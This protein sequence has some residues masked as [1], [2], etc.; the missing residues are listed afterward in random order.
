MLNVLILVFLFQAT[1]WHPWKKLD[2][3]EGYRQGL[4]QSRQGDVFLSAGRRVFMSADFGTSWRAIADTFRSDVT[5]I[6]IDRDHITVT[7]MFPTNTNSFVEYRGFG[8][9]NRPF[10]LEAFETQYVV[11]IYE[12]KPGLLSMF[13]DVEFGF[14]PQYQTSVD[15]GKTW[16][17]TPDAQKWA[18]RQDTWSIDG[19]EFYT[20]QQRRNPTFMPIQVDALYR[21]ADD[22]TTAVFPFSKQTVYSGWAVSGGWNFPKQVFK[23]RDTLFAVYGHYEGG[24]LFFSLDNGRNFERLNS[25]PDSLSQ[26]VEHAGGMLASRKS[27]LYQYK[28]SGWQV[29]HTFENP[30][31]SL[32]SAP[33]GHVFVEASGVFRGALTSVSNEVNISRKPAF[34]LA[35]FPNPFN[36]STVIRWQVPEAGR[37]VLTVWDV[38]GRMVRT[39]ENR[40]VAAGHQ[41]TRF[42]AAGLA[43]GVY[44]V[45]L[46]MQGNAL[47][48]RKITLLK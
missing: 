23:Q 42:D 17:H 13:Y 1:G 5:I 47:L 29:V 16:H 9:V 37:A 38:N 10:Q 46:E 11:D 3:P 19:V 25:Q 35:A 21:L 43:S 12:V 6:P 31:K 39:L 28:T 40:A 2:L 41:E 7:G 22:S 24:E 33:S 27:V 26:I 32:Y 4:V 18:L 34:A 8:G 15:S 45:R 44:I 30:I 36:P 48:T 14:Q 20:R